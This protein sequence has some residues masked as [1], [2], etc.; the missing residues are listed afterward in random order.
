VLQE[1]AVAIDADRGQRTTDSLLL[2][3][4]NVHPTGRRFVPGHGPLGPGES[5]EVDAALALRLV[6]D[7]LVFGP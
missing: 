6:D 2:R 1:R 4:H 3:L 5:C 7:R